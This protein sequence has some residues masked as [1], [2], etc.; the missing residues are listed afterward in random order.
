MEW[1]MEKELVVAGAVA[2]VMAVAIGY[3]APMS[4]A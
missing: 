1:D 3:I 4:L 2:G